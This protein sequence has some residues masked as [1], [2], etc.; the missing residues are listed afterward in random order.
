MER[1]HVFIGGTV[2][3]L[4][5][6]LGIVLGAIHLGSARPETTNRDDYTTFTAPQNVF[7]SLQRSDDE[8]PRA[9]RNESLNSTSLEQQQAIQN[10][11][12]SWEA[13]PGS[14][15]A[16]AARNTSIIIDTRTPEEIERDEISA[17][18]N[19]LIGTKITDQFAQ[20]R[21]QTTNSSDAIWLGEY[22][23]TNSPT[24]S[25]GNQT[26]TQQALRVY[27]NELGS[28]LKSFQLAQGDQTKLLEDFLDN[29]ADTT[30]LKRL[31]DAYVE[32]GE[33][34]Q[35]ISAPDVLATTHTGLANSYTQVGELL[36]NITLANDDEALVERML[37]YNKASEEV[38]KHHVSL[39]TLFK[40]HGIEFQPHEPG[41]IFTFN[42]Q[43]QTSL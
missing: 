19:D 30:N 1:A 5:A 31:T 26:Q 27:G 38:A 23:N 7:S 13:R 9:L 39:I 11:I 15:D 42:P 16:R 33:I 43:G 29:R 35:A 21:P 17:L 12:A 34:I 25:E 32:L 4:I 24:V 3:L 28:T 18:F 8:Q 6:T 41:S 36:W 22:S 37:I 2:F 20:Q 14:S 40:A 10:I